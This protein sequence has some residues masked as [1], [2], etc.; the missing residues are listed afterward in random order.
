MPTDVIADLVS[1][2]GAG[3]EVTE[4]GREP[5]PAA[6]TPGLVRVGVHRD[7]PLP[8]EGLDSF[9]ILLAGRLD[10]PRPWVGLSSDVLD[11]TTARLRAA[12]LRQPAAAAAAAQVL[13]MGG[14]MDFGQALVLESLAYSMLLA[15]EGFR[16]WRVANPPRP[17]GEDAAPRVLID[18][19]ATEITL[20]LNRPSV[21]NAFDARMRDELAEALAFAREHPD[22][23]PVTLRAEGPAF[24]SGGDLAEFGAAADVGQAHLIRTLRAPTLLVHSLGARLTAHLHGACVG[25]GIETP[26][27]ASRVTARPGS[28]FRLPEVSMGLIPGAGGTASIRR[29]IGRRRACY[30]AISGADIDLATALAWG[31]VDEVAA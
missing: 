13:R 17:R 27:A 8:E 29:R 19:S 30:M 21:R 2:S 12:V 14:S 22:A 5:T 18:V 28:Y 20:R 10:A 16:A 11:A 3:V 4:L 6:D 31:L 23:L 24:S 9:D 1:L 26:A 25:A 15:S 7:G